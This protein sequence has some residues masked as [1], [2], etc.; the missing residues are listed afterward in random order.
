[1]V[2]KCLP[3]RLSIDWL[4]GFYWEITA[5]RALS[6]LAELCINVIFVMT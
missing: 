1:M 2:L 6:F 3:A 5:K 4:I